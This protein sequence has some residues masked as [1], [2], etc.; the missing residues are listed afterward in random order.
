MKFVN[1]Q[2]CAERREWLSERAKESYNSIQRAI[3]ALTGGRTKQ[4]D[5]ETEQPTDRKS[6]RVD[7]NDKDSGADQ[8]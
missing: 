7:S 1:C 3:N 2:G 8:H 4:P 6:K 5:P